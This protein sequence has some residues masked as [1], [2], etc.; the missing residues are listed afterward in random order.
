LFGEQLDSAMISEYKQ[1][2]KGAVPGKLVVGTKSPDT[3]SFQE[4]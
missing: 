4:H 3:L 2:N 1:L